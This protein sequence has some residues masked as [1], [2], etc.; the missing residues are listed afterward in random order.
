MKYRVPCI[1]NSVCFFSR[2]EGLFYVL[3]RTK[4]SLC[5]S[6]F[7]TPPEPSTF[8]CLY[9]SSLSFCHLGLMKYSK[10][11]IRLNCHDT[12]EWEI[13]YVYICVCVFLPWVWESVRE[14]AGSKMLS[15]NFVCNRDCY[16]QKRASPHIFWHISHR[17]RLK[18]Q[19]AAA[20]TSCC[21]KHW[22][23]SIEQQQQHATV[24][25]DNVSNSKMTVSTRFRTP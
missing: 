25:L 20:Y 11:H 5:S 18:Q 23:A 16:C 7:D 6:Y 17:E 8:V 22:T 14:I 19:K 10:Q 24:V 13:I 1:K 3:V 2:W 4:L 9:T 12:Y 15:E 21:Q